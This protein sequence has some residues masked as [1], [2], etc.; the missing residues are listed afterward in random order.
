[1]GFPLLTLSLMQGSTVAADPP[2]EVQLE[3]L[4]TLEALAARDATVLR[5]EDA[6]NSI[7]Q[8]AAIISQLERELDDLKQRS[9][10]S[11]Q[12]PITARTVSDEHQ[13]CSEKHDREG[14]GNDI[15]LFLIEAVFAYKHSQVKSGTRSL[16]QEDTLLSPPIHLDLFPHTFQNATETLQSNSAY[17]SLDSLDSTVREPFTPAVDDEAEYQVSAYR[18]PWIQTTLH[19]AT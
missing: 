4:R 15:N 1:M 6:Y 3:R 5:L 2:V 7:R 16:C 17:R 18:Q 8:K 11:T 13:Q 19:C 10:P 14:L 9:T 12:V